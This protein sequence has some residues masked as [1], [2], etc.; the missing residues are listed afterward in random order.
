MR[1]T[2]PRTRARASPNASPSSIGYPSKEIGE[3]NL[4][5]GVSG[6]KIGDEV[7]PIDDEGRIIGET[8]P[9]IGV[10]G[11]IIGEANPSIGP[12]TPSNGAADPIPATLPDKR[13]GKN[14]MGVWWRSTFLYLVRRN[15]LP[16]ETC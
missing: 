11:Q 12:H 15:Q 6:Q 5:I 16:D 13:Y 7:R 10:G 2:A 8:R 4:S 1:K 3:A 14:L 9:S